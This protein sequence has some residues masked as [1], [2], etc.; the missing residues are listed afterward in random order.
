M[1]DLFA[2]RAINFHTFIKHVNIESSLYELWDS[3]ALSIDSSV[4]YQAMEQNN[5]WISER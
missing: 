5:T 3:V 1:T 2:G 4:K